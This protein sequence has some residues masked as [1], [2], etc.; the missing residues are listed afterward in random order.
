MLFGNSY[1]AAVWRLYIVRKGKT[2][3]RRRKK[4]NITRHVLHFVSSEGTGHLSSHR[5]LS[6]LHIFYEDSIFKQFGTHQTMLTRLILL[7]HSCDLLTN[8]TN[9]PQHLSSLGRIFKGNK[10][11]TGKLKKKKRRRNFC[12]PTC[13]SLSKTDRSQ[14]KKRNPCSC[15]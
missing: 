15:G 4:C 6:L 1:I 5:S 13:Q 10:H 3:Q 11:Q 9:F 12:K 8:K 2:R 7:A 14:R